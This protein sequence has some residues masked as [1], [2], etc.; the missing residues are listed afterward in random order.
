MLYKWSLVEGCLETENQ[1]GNW[2]SRKMVW[3]M[4][5]ETFYVFCIA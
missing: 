4:V 5:V 3:K 2:L 1:G